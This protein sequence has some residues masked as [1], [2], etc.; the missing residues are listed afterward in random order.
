M[1]RSGPLMWYIAR[2]SERSSAFMDHSPDDQYHAGKE[3]GSDPSSSYLD[4]KVAVSYPLNT[5]PAL[6]E[7]SGP[8]SHMPNSEG[9]MDRRYRDQETTVSSTTKL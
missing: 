7:K 4:S 8:L 5:I 2:L 9:D 6:H 1:D 3:L